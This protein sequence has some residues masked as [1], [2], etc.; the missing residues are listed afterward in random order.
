V[1]DLLRSCSSSRRNWLLE[2][3]DP[4]GRLRDQLLDARPH[5]LHRFFVT[6]GSGE[7][8]RDHVV[9][10]MT[11]LLQISLN[12]AGSIRDTLFDEVELRTRQT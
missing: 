4:A 3:P 5:D 8:C 7:K 12:A 1:R 6:P 11:H 10:L 9:V 2:S